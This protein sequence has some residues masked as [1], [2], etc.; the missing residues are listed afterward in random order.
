[1][2]IKLGR[3]VVTKRR[4]YRVLWAGPNPRSTTFQ[5]SDISRTHLYLL[6]EIAVDT[7]QSSGADRPLYGPDHP[8]N[9]R[10]DLQ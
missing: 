3:D 6:V 10:M 1:M 8:R 5:G 4:A 2:C 9:A 7:I